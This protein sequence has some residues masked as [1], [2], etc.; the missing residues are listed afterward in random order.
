[1]LGGIVKHA[2]PGPLIDYLIRPKGKASKGSD[3]LESRAELLGGTLL[4]V[5]PGDIKEAF[6][7]LCRR[8]PDVA[9]PIV[10]IWISCPDGVNL[11]AETWLALCER[12]AEDFQLS[13]WT[14]YRHL[15]SSHDHIHLV[16]SRIGWDLKVSRERLRDYRCLADALRRCER[17]L[18]LPAFEGP[19][20]DP[21]PHGRIKA[22]KASPTKQKGRSRARLI[23]DL[24]KDMAECEALGYRSIQMLQELRKRNWECELRW[25]DGFI[26]GVTWAHTSG[27]RV[28]GAKL[29]PEY[30][31]ATWMRRIGGIPGMRVGRLLP[32]NWVP[33]PIRTDPR[34]FRRRPVSSRPWLLRLLDWVWDTILDHQKVPDASPVQAPPRRDRPKPTPPTSAEAPLSPTPSRRRR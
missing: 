27:F 12:I 34:I 19:Q 11:D 30:R 33:R 4:E 6:A 32:A 5:T 15:D 29:G 21:R 22:P 8:R 28:R 7:N 31:G 18:A 25:K 24:R 26:S 14:A 10:H 1:M 23:D 2:A 3:R 9:K 17:E 13:I 20:R 16:G